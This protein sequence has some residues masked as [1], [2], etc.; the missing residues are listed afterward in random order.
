M[1]A[2]LNRLIS[3]EEKRRFLGN[4]FSLLTLQGLNYI[5]PLLTLPYLVRVLGAEKFGLL[6][7][8]TAIIGYFIVLTDYG[9]NFTATREVAL[10]RENNEKLNEI[11]SSVMIIKFL[12]FMVSLLMLVLLVS[13]F[14]KFSVDPWLY[15]LTFGTV[16]GQILFPV[17][18]FQGIEQMRHVTIIN[19]IFKTLFTLTIFLFV[20]ESSDYL[21]VPLLT[22]LGMVFAGLYSLI[23]MYRKFN[24]RFKFQKVKIIFGYLKGGSNLF[25]TAAL[26]NLLISSGTIVLSF[27]S[28]NTVVGYYSAAEKMFRAIVGLFTPVTQALYPV[29]CRKLVDNTNAKAY[30]R[31]LSLVIG[32][33]ALT[34]ATSVAFLSK[35]IM[36]LVYGVAFQ[37][38]SYILAIMMIW[39][40]FG[41]INNIIGIQY[42]SASRNDKFYTLSFCIAGI[43]TV[44]LNFLLIPHLLMNGILIS[45]IS[46]EILLTICMLVL[47]FRFK[48]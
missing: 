6:A 10:H 47:I 27:V 26:G 14:N 44:L 32:G 45:M 24:I 29:S 9:F 12:L 25:L 8:S 48:L 42:L 7:F 43:V 22:S 46:G 2:K 41:V 17:W 23:I 13:N 36:T 5:L 20:K 34:V 37:S 40:F 30:I 1:L 18:F 3:N 28:T 39:L 33:I 31:K 21:L 11:F 19:I 35:E 15:Y 4:F 38:Y 16:F